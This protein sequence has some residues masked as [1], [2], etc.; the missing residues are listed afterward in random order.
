MN[1]A[2][3][4][5]VV[6]YWWGRGNTN[7]NTQRPCPD[8]RRHNKDGSLREL[9]RK[10][11]TYDKMIDRWESACRRH[12]CNFMAVEYPEFASVKGLL[13]QK[14]NYKGQFILESLEACAPRSVLYID[15]DMLIQRYPKLFDMPDIDYAGRSWNLDQREE[16]FDE[17]S[18][19]CLIDPYVYET[20]GGTQ[21]FGQTKNARS[22]LKYWIAESK[23]LS[24]KADDRILGYTI[25][26][27]NWL[28]TLNMIHLPVE[29]LWFNDLYTD[30]DVVDP[31]YVKDYYAR[32][33]WIEHPECLTDEERALTLSLAQVKA[34]HSRIPRMFDSLI[35]DRVACRRTREPTTFYEY[36]YFP[37]RSFVSTLHTPLKALDRIGSLRLIE[38]SDRYGPTY[39]QV[40]E[41][42]ERAVANLA[43]NQRA[44]VESFAHITKD[45][46]NG[47]YVFLT[48]R[49][50]TTIP[51]LLLALK[52]GHDV[53]FYDSSRTSKLTPG[54]IA[55]RRGYLES[56]IWSRRDLD[57]EFACRNVNRSTTR[58]YRR[59]YYLEIDPSYPMYFS[60]RSRV[61]NHLLTMC[62][63]LGDLA[64]VF[65]SSYIFLTRIRCKWI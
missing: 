18:E 10:G 38:Y 60:H 43:H 37:E 35:T 34:S 44:L 20:S 9:T 50:T 27:K 42:N 36:I 53:V 32:V 26:L 13:Q 59:D 3:N 16:L 22:L 33:P 14:I 64:K 46:A 41:R 5:V 19:S 12:R 51:L 62:R 55:R 47:K 54:S 21:F 48:N 58:R 45:T 15:G 28:T 65:N 2:S 6:T 49:D 1:P 17:S 7:A 52:L 23:R 8:Q 11:I 61:L 57:V 39:N 31:S 40:A 63:T 56:S 25:N 24:I 4:F 29:Y 30:P